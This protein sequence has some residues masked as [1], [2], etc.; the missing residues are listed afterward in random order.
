MDWG[1]L[2]M[3]LIPV[4]ILVIEYFVGK[5]DKVESNSM[6]EIVE[7]VLKLVAN[8]FVTKKPK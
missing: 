1:Q 6:L 3:V 2:L 7:K 5:S 4:I 8:L